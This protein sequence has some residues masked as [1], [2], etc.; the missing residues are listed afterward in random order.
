[1]E[2]TK[3]ELGRVRFAN[4][5]LT[6][7]NQ[8]LRNENQ[9]LRK[10]NQKL[11]QDCD[12]FVNEIAVL[13]HKKT[14]NNSSIAPSKD[15]NRL[16]TTS[17]REKSGKTNG[18]QIGHEGITLDFIA[19][20]DKIEPHKPDYCTSC[21]AELT[22]D[23]ILKETRQ[24]IDIPPIKP[25]VT[26]HRIFS[27]TCACGVCTV[28]EFPQ[29]VNGKVSYGPTVEALCGYL[30]VRQYVSINRIEEIFRDVFGIQIS[31]GTI[32]NRINTLAN[33]CTDTY[34]LIRSKVEQSKCVG[35]DETGCKVNKA[36]MWGWAWQTPSLTYIAVSD[37]RGYETI[38]IN[39]PKGLPN[40][41]LVHDCWSAHFKTACKIHQLCLEHIRR[42]LKYFTENGDAPW[43]K[44]FTKFILGAQK[45]KK[46]ILANPTKSFRIEI[47]QTKDELEKLLKETH[48]I[49]V[50]GELTLAN[51]LLKHKN[52]ILP[53]LDYRF[54]PPDN[55]GSE[56]AMR[57]YKVKL[58]VSGFFKTL[59]GAQ[60]YAVIRSVTD[61]TIKNGG[62][63]LNALSLLNC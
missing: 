48:Q 46:S 27:R 25:I 1:L 9:Q 28:G 19:N 26:E 4:T 2:L 62:S 58:K 54:V 7:E 24:V 45:L 10:E 29:S 15:E 51:R 8:Q 47:A 21:G 55:N 11:R 41:V 17:L 13:K 33:K 43:A 39:F 61:T 18:G 59:I 34:E 14:S 20:P 30:S 36:K 3:Q 35:V 44:S 52:Y 37:N 12:K 56:R 5:L 22:S 40:A 23:A 31:Q 6:I 42:E 32:V 60:N 16:K 50:K 53:F 38:N 57:N 49:T 63:P